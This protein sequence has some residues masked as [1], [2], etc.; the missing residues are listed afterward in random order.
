[1]CSHIVFG[2]LV[3]RFGDD[4]RLNCFTQDG[5]VNTEHGNFFNSVE[6]AYFLFYLLRADTK[7]FYF[8]ECHFCAQ[9]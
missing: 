1:M 7:A 6:K 3:A 5:I 8:D 2:N 9:R 4:T